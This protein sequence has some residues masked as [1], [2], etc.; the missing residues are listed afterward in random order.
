M[1]EG[2][3]DLF[4]RGTSANAATS[5]PY[6]PRFFI[7]MICSYRLL[8]GKNARARSRFRRLV[9][10]EEQRASFDPLLT[11]L[12]GSP[13]KDEPLYRQINAPKAKNIYS[14]SDFPYLGNR[15]LVLQRH[16]DSLNPSDLRTLYY[17]RRNVLQFYTFWAVLVVGGIS[18]LLS[19]AQTVLTAVQVGYL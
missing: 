15:L 10:T 3:R 9:F 4:E 18:I 11:S 12:C 19:L 5:Q 1:G 13:W 16:V 8:F 17:D 2:N 14:Q 7:E 6:G